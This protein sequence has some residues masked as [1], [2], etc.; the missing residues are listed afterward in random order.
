MSEERRR[1]KRTQSVVY[2]R[3]ET[4][5][6]SSCAEDTFEYGRQLGLATQPGEVYAP[7]GGRG[8]GNIEKVLTQGL[9]HWKIAVS[10]G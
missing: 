4:I 5:M 2:M 8:T 1:G 3:K 6:Q 10:R 9:D 7:I